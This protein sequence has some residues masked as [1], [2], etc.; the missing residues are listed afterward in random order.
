MG[1]TCACGSVL[2]DEKGLR[3][4]RK[5]HCKI[6]PIP[7]VLPEHGCEECDKKF[8]TLGGLQQHRR[9][10]HRLLYNRECELAAEKYTTRAWTNEDRRRLAIE[11][12]R[13][14][15]DPNITRINDALA[16]IFGRTV[17]SIR[18]QR[19]TKIYLEI[20]ED[21]VNELEDG[22]LCLDPEPGSPAQPKVQSEVAQPEIQQVAGTSLGKAPCITPALIPAITPTYAPE[23]IEPTAGPS[24]D[25]EA[26]NGDE[27]EFVTPPS[28]P[29]LP[30]GMIGDL[31]LSS[32]LSAEKRAEQRELVT[33]AHCPEVPRPLNHGPQGISVEGYNDVEGTNPSQDRLSEVPD[34]VFGYL[35][36]SVQLP[37][38]KDFQDIFSEFLQGPWPSGRNIAGCDTWRTEG[39]FSAGTT[40]GCGYRFSA[41]FDWDWSWKTGDSSSEDGSPSG[42]KEEEKEGWTL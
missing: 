19:R 24:G 4:R 30:G 40:R 27:D 8:N 15:A 29:G 28:S 13:V 25:P 26:P 12:L 39:K 32:P 5:Y 21:V 17:D 6:N 23:T 36:T 7:E 42:S 2:K 33:T 37:A 34:P 16:T 9:L 41:G 20:Y 22:V 10:A 11:E 38:L 3:K 18:G 1:V 35:W 31:H 14:M